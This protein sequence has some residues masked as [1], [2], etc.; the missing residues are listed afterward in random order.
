MLEP[1]G[2]SWEDGKQPDAMTL[3]PWQGGKNVTWDV[4]V[5]DTVTDS[6]T[7]NSRR[8]VQVARRKWEEESLS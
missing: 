8:R 3:I 7:Y 5:T 2:L 1:S 4:T 6:S